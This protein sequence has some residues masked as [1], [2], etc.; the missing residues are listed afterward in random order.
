MS[1]V[2]CYTSLF[3]IT[4]GSLHSVILNAIFNVDSNYWSGKKTSMRPN[5][6]LRHD[7]TL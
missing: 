7:G 5:D 2:I 6:V 3:L 4:T 1:A